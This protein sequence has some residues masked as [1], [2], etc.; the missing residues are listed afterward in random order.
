MKNLMSSLLPT[1]M[2]P[3]VEVMAETQNTYL[4]FIRDTMAEKLVRAY[5]KKLEFLPVIKFS[6]SKKPVSL[7]LVPSTRGDSCD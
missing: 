6:V 2:S 5:S 7:L 3:T 4:F 1:K